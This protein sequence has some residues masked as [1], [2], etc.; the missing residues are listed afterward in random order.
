[1]LVW[2]DTLFLEGLIVGIFISLV[3]HL[4]M[5]YC[6][7]QPAERKNIPQCAG[8]SLV[9]FQE[10]TELNLLQK[11]LLLQLIS[12][13]KKLSEK[14]Q[15]FIDKINDYVEQ[16]LS[17]GDC[18]VENLIRDMGMSRTSFCDKLKRIA[19]VA[20]KY[21]IS[22]YKITKASKLLINTDLIMLDIACS[23]G[24]CDESHFRKSFKKYYRM[25]PAEY[26]KKYHE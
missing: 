2:G 8:D 21:Y 11:D 9:V 3:V 10:Q 6:Q 24:Y 16:H 5:K 25:C 12:G 1:M 4:I 23:L 14:D 22:F 20:P 19:G 18:M 13:E 26:R 7:L 15:L 17:E